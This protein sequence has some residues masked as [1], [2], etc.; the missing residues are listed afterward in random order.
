MSDTSGI[1]AMIEAGAKRIQELAKS[2]SEV[3]Q[4]LEYFGKNPEAFKQ[5]LKDCNLKRKQP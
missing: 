5:Y 4:A 3:R 2:E 1:N